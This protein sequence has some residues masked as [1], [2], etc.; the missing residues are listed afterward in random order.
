MDSMYDEHREF[1]KERAD[2]PKAGS[3]ITNDM[4]VLAAENKRRREEAVSDRLQ[5]VQRALA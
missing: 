1:L 3:E 2:W 5:L 4:L